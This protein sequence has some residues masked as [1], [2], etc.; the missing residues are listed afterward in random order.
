MTTVTRKI[1]KSCERVYQDNSWKEW[2]RKHHNWHF[3]YTIYLCPFHKC[4]EN[5]HSE[6]VIKTLAE[7]NSGLDE[8]WGA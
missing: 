1:C 3:G 7:M 4:R 8:M 2:H 5:E 6:Y